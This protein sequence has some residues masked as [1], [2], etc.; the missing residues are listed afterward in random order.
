MISFVIFTLMSLSYVW[1]AQPYDVKC[2]DEADCP[3]WMAGLSHGK[4]VCSTFLVTDSIMATNL[5]CIPEELRNDGQDCKGKISAFFPK[6]SQFQA[7]VAECDSILFT[8]PP[9]VK[10]MLSPDF[11]FFKLT[12]PVNRAVLELSQVGMSDM[13]EMTVYKVDPS[14]D[15][16][17]GTIRKVLCTAVQNSMINPFFNSDKSPL[18][19]LMPCHTIPGNSG[20]PILSA[21]GKVRGI[22]SAKSQDLVIIADPEVKAGMP[23][24]VAAFGSNFSCLNTYFLGF[25]H[26]VPSDCRVNVDEKTRR[27]MLQKISAKTFEEVEAALQ[28]K[29]LESFTVLAQQTKRS[30]RWKVKQTQASEEEV[31]KNILG[32]LELEPECLIPPAGDPAVLQAKLRK[33][34]TYLPLSWIRYQV[35]MDHDRYYRPKAKLEEERIPAEFVFTPLNFLKPKDIPVRIEKAR[36]PASVGTTPPASAGPVAASGGVIKTYNVD[37]CKPV[38]P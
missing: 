5:H 32:N 37:L 26:G 31:K 2:N 33:S 14:A 10:D 16:R 30:V 24:G 27:L 20:S 11:A 36:A 4:G 28:K 9:L 15:K 6:T 17:A 8:S 38:A 25:N 22:I 35:R 18:V 13:T 23:E 12:K 3:G 34:D 1:S 19:T 7:E 29:L 21:D